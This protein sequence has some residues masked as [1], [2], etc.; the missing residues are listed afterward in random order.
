MQSKPNNFAHSVLF[1]GIMVLLASTELPAQSLTQIQKT[2]EQKLEAAME[3]LRQQRKDIKEAKIPLAR[4]LNRL[5]SEVRS[6]RDKRDRIRRLRDSKSVELGSLRNRVERKRDQV[7]YVR[8]S[9]IPEYIATY[10]AALSLGERSRHGE[11]IRKHN[12]FQERADPSKEDK[13]KR[14]LALI[15]DSL[16]RLREVMGGTAYEGEA[17]SQNGMAYEG[18]FLQIGPLLYFKPGQTGENTPA[19][20]VI[21]REGN[22]RPVIYGIS[23]PASKSIDTVLQQREGQLY[24]DP[25]N[26]DAVALMETKDTLQ[27]HLDKGGIWVYPILFFAA[28]SALAAITKMIQ[29]FR[30]RQPK[31]GVIQELVKHLRA[32]ETQ[33]AD[34]LL[35]G[36]PEPT[37]GMLKGA[38]E[39]AGESTELVEEVLYEK[40]LDI[41]PR[42]ERFLNV[43]A[44]TAAAAPLLGLLGTVT[45]IIKTF[46]LMSVF[47]AGDP[48]PLISGISE[49]LITTELGLILAIPALVL[50]AL[51]SRKVTGIM[52]NL[53]KIALN[54]INGLSRKEESPNKEEDKN[55]AY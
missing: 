5:E 17:Y 16:A 23:E 44:V 6:L 4:K 18:Q 36:Q 39:H 48:K 9:L 15:Q 25:T 24:V 13:M 28:A 34:K 2:Q 49:A 55:A 31:T 35:E 3:D 38:L 47:G 45:G 43:I 32:G 26:G 29:I 50:H 8:Q 37:R 20:G 21:L 41:Q 11:S 54:V 22:E 1:A 7:N 27:E 52:S 33:K 46:E 42:L 53:E 14:S 10:D 30:I 19:P 51:L 40:M 12:L